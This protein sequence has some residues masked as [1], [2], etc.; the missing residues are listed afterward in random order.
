MLVFLSNGEEVFQK[1]C[2]LKVQPK[3]KNKQKIATF[4]M[5]IKV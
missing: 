2:G 3:S 5:K 1:M 4:V